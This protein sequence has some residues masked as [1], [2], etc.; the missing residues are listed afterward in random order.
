MGWQAA[1]GLQLRASHLVAA[2]SV[3][4]GK[5]RVYKS[6]PA[7]RFAVIPAAE[8]DAAQPSGSGG[9]VGGGGGAA[10]QVARRSQVA[11]AIGA[12]GSTAAAGAP[13]RL[14]QACCILAVE[15]CM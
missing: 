4:D 9:N 15:V 3:G 2:K 14:S 6:T 11:A 8:A 5:P 13:A 7:T 1:G 10:P 12:A